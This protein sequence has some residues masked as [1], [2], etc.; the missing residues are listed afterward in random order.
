MPSALLSILNELTSLSSMCMY[1]S[2]SVSMRHMIR[3]KAHT[4]DT[5]LIRSCACL[6]I[7]IFGTSLCASHR[8]CHETNAVVYG[9]FI[10]DIFPLALMC[11]FGE[12]CALIYAV[13]FC[14]ITSERA[15]SLKICTIAFIPV[16]LISLYS[17]L[18]WTG[19]TGQSNHVTGVVL[20]YVGLAISLGFYALPFATS[21]TVLRTKSA[22]TI[23]IL[24]ISIG[25][26]SNVL[27]SI[28]SILQNDVFVLPPNTVCFCLDLLQVLLY[29]KYNPNRILDNA[30]DNFPTRRTSST[31]P[32]GVRASRPCPLLCRLSTAA[33]WSRV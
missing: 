15:A 27:W 18:A 7:A 17:I 33:N 4:G 29:T 25:T 16:P 2:P 12:V 22:A 30:H 14:S 9:L 1:V 11:L 3:A 8:H 31:E 6:A 21:R 32:F 10:D 19:V 5:Q 24:I 23:P 20:G 28:Y 26:I 13:I